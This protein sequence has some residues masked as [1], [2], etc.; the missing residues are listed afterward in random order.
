[1]N[2]TRVVTGA[3][4]AVG[5]LS[6]AGADPFSPELAARADVRF[7]ASPDYV[8]Q[9]FFPDV[10][11]PCPPTG[12]PTRSPEP[13]PASGDTDLPQGRCPGRRPDPRP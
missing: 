5:T 2:R 12:P 9:D 11:R 4:A 6:L 3:A 10:F 8:G 13:L 1:M 7:L